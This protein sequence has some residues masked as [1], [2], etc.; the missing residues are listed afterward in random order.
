M[1]LSLIVALMF[2]AIS[3]YGKGMGFADGVKQEIISL[4]SDEEVLGRL[5]IKLAELN[6]YSY[7][8]HWR[9]PVAGGTSEVNLIL[10]PISEV[11]LDRVPVELVNMILTQMDFLDKLENTLNKSNVRDLE[12]TFSQS[13]KDIYL[14]SNDKKIGQYTLLDNTYKRVYMFIQ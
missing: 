5:G 4:Y 3:S 2:V 6:T 14:F 10:H 9:K 7:Q 11:N 8:F 1:K 13:M 12:M